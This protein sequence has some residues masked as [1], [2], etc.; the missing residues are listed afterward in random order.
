MSIWNKV[1]IGFI[2]VAAIAFFL[3][4]ARALKTHA[5]WRQSVAAH[6]EAIAKLEE[7]DQKLRDGEEGKP[8]IRR[9]RQELAEM[10]TSRPQIWSGCMPRNV[11]AQT[12]VVSV[13][14]DSLGP[15]RISVKTVV[16]VFDDGEVSKGGRYL[17]KFVVGQVGDK[18]AVLNPAYP[19]TPA[20][21]TR[22]QQARGPWSLHG[23]LPVDDNR[24]FAELD[25]TAKKAMLPATTVEEYLKDA[26]DDQGEWKRKLRD[27]KVLLDLSYRQRV[28]MVKQTEAATRDLQYLTA[29]VAG[30]EE[31]KKF[32]EQM[33][34]TLQDELA[35][36]QVEWKAATDHEK[37]LEERLAV[38]KAA[39][40]QLAKQNQAA[41]A[42]LA[43][44]QWEATQR[45]EDRARRMA[46]VRGMESH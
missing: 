41:A 6:E 37:A 22:L 10:A 20:E 16:H 27:Y 28:D 15:Q 12:G 45:I 46:H 17:G 4:A 33:L 24:M 3:F 34:K 40:E 7:S 23:S 14:G 19:I 35:R 1:L 18:Q 44:A 38:M 32:F 13:D 8:G 11:V 39:V 2:F 42:Q 36:A 31:Q 25:D 30:Q 9:L 26:K 21:V 43:R 29:T 5:A